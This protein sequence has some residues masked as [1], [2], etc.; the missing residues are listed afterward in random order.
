MRGYLGILIMTNQKLRFSSFLGSFLFKA[1]V[2][3]IFWSWSAFNAL[4]EILLKRTD[5]YRL[6]TVQARL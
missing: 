5:S 2:L 4:K 6:T 1:L 3:S